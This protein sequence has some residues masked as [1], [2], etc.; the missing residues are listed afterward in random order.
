MAGDASKEFDVVFD[1][2]SYSKQREYGSLI[3]LYDG[4]RTGIVLVNRLVEV[5]ESDLSTFLKEIGGWQVTVDV[6]SETVTTTTT[7]REA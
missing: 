6:L 2:W 3:G 1:R 4:D 7:E 5:E